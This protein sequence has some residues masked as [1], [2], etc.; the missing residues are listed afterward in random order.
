MTDEKNLPLK[1]SE[2]KRGALHHS[3]TP[4]VESQSETDRNA[5]EEE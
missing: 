2:K 4:H 3:D 1:S 5:G